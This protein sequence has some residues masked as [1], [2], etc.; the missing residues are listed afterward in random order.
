MKGTKK[1]LFMLFATALFSIFAC[2]GVSAAT[3]GLY[4]YSSTTGGVTITKYTGAEKNLKIPA[5]LGKKTVVGF[6]SSFLQQ[7]N[8]VQTITIPAG[9]KSIPASAFA[10]CPNLQAVTLA[11]TGVQ[12]V[13]NSAFSGCTKLTSFSF[14]K[15]K[16]NATI[17]T[18]AFYNTGLTSVDI[19]YSVAS[20]GATSFA[21]CTHLQNVNIEIGLRTIGANAFANCLSLAKVNLPSS[22]SSIGATIFAGTHTSP[23]NVEVVASTYAN[24]YMTSNYPEA[25]NAGNIKTTVTARK[26]AT[27]SFP[28]SMVTTYVG[29]TEKLALTKSDTT[30]TITWSSTDTAKATVDNYGNVTVKKGG[31]VDIIARADNQTYASV[32]L[33]IYAAPKTITLIQKG[34]KASTSSHSMKDTGELL[35]TWTTTPSVSKNAPKAI[36]SSNTKV[37]P[38]PQYD[39]AK[40]AYVVKPVQGAEGTVTLTV[41]TYNGKSATY[42][43]TV[44]KT[45]N[46]IPNWTQKS[47]TLV[48]GKSF[49]LKNV[50][51]MKFSSSNTSIATVSSKGKITAKKAGKATITVYNATTSANCVVTVNPKKAAISKLSSTAKKKITVKYKK[52]SGITGYEIWWRRSDMKWSKSR[53]KTRAASK[54]NQI[55]INVTKSKAKFYVR[56][57]AYRKVGGKKYYGAFCTPKTIKSK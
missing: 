46:A 21:N 55:T 15:L 57:R 12:S 40:G 42:K 35:L 47:K 9:V 29:R 43:I 19:P 38:N 20:I 51:G 26:T 5:T 28:S 11:G 2:V 54:S 3:S 45:R 13:G 24:N 56:V 41:K 1:A 23:V 22:V 8:Y 16:E 31:Y 52:L 36:T 27:L 48:V 7:K 53:M 39:S 17:G 6:S 4:T 30:D 34:K 25:S 10:N 49:T 44:T 50:S 32:T 18:S 14:E 37:I 33:R